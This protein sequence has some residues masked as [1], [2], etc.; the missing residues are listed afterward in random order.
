MVK[1]IILFLFCFS[2]FIVLYLGLVGGGEHIQRQPTVSSSANYWYMS[3]IK[4]FMQSIT[5]IHCLKAMGA[6][7]TG[8]KR[9]FK[10]SG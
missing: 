4:M 5:E 9:S 2:I 10:K 8:T 3:T 7:P 6:Y 1:M